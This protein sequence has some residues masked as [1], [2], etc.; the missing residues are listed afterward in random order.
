MEPDQ[1]AFIEWLPRILIWAFNALM[2]IILSIGA[3]LWRSLVGE[4]KQLGKRQTDLE[5]NV[6]SNKLEA[7][8]LYAK[9]INVQQTLAR[10]HDRLDDVSKDIKELIRAV[11]EK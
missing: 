7:S 2:V 8:N 10:L 5:L 6:I 4:V 3:W 11:A 1:T 9:E